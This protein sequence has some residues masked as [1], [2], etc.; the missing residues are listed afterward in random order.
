VK[1]YKSIFKESD[2]TWGETKYG[3]SYLKAVR[4]CPKGYRLPTIE[5]LEDAH[6]NNVSGFNKVE[7]DDEDIEGTT[8]VYWSSTMVNPN[9][10]K[11]FMFL[12]GHEKVDS[13]SP[14][15]NKLAVRYVKK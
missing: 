12:K 1:P 13:L 11:V 15:S 4:D 10:Y 7:L 8:T 14:R 2:V 3:V 5:E 6:N 9:E